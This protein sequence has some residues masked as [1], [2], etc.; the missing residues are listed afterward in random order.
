MWCIWRTCPSLNLWSAQRANLEIVQTT[1]VFRTDL[2]AYSVIEDGKYSRTVGS[3]EEF[4]EQMANFA[5]FYLGCSFSFD[6][7]LLSAGVPLRN[8]DKNG[9]GNTSMYTVSEN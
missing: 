7:R 8:L 1:F 9:V 3:L 2:T 4:G 6:K 5:F